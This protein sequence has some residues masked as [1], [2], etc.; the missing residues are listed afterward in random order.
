M[1]PINKAVRAR[2]E[3]FCYSECLN[4]SAAALCMGGIY[5]LDRVVVQ[6]RGQLQKGPFDLEV[7]KVH[8]W[9]LCQGCF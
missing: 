5:L 2:A 6:S 8:G 9:M 4:S 3:F 7:A 1:S